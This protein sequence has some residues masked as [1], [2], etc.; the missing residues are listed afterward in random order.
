MTVAYLT[1]K[2][3]FCVI[4]KVYCNKH[5]SPASQGSFTGH[6]SCLEYLSSLL[7]DF[8]TIMAPLQIFPAPSST[9]L[10]LLCR[11]V[12]L[13]YRILRL[14][15]SRLSLISSG[16]SIALLRSRFSGTLEHQLKTHLEHREHL[17]SLFSRLCVLTRIT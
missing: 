5:H 17:D 15:Y 12:W 14:L 7:T 3:L 11:H 6:F 8:Q 16:S 1:T 4:T 9:G 13:L 10:R 2:A